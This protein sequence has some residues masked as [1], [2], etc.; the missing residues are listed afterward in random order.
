MYIDL[1]SVTQHVGCEVNCVP[2]DS[3][4]FLIQQDI[5]REI[6]NTQSHFNKKNYINKL[7]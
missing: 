7:N 4:F 5:S 6:W 2:L 1:H 3:A